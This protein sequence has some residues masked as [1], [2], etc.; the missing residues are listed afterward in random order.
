LSGGCA[1]HNQH[2]RE[3]QKRIWLVHQRFTTEFFQD[4]GT[5]TRLFE[6]SKLRKNIYVFSTN[7]KRNLDP[8][9]E[10][11][12]D[13]FLIRSRYLATLSRYNLDSIGSNQFLDRIC[14]LPVAGCCRMNLIASTLRLRSGWTLLEIKICYSHPER[15]RRVDPPKTNLKQPAGQTGI[16]RI[17]FILSKVTEF[18]NENQGCGKW[19]IIK[20]GVT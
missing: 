14:S 10:K 7:N 4:Y 15:S 17:S 5:N 12:L 8:L 20:S 19:T 16:N 13:F 6:L 2:S 18:R 11:T 1:A 3:N 9:S